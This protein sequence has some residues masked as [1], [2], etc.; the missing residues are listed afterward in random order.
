MNEADMGG[1]R[2]R[3]SALMDSFEVDAHLADKAFEDLAARYGENGRHYHTLAH[4]ENVLETADALRPF[5]QDFPAVELAAWF[6]DIIY[7]PR[8]AD[9][10]AQ[11]ADY[12]ARVLGTMGLPAATI[13][14]VERLIRATTHAYPCPDDPDCQ[15]L[16]DADLATFGSNW[17]L[18]EEIAAAIRQEFS[19]VP[20]DT[21][22]VGRR[23]VLKQ[24][25]QRD[26][27]FYNPKMFAQ[28]EETAR[29]N[30]AQAIAALD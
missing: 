15:V 21:Y 10:E 22:R 25:L 9:N 5:A 7:D 27:I 8:A 29:Q 23:Q 2:E 19:F 11:S 24:F 30:I 3:W 14:K 28:F 13:A 17:P 26:R 12:A 4:I 16:L 6:H 1:L 20:E 18:Q